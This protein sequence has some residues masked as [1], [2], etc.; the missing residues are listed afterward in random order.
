MHT[1]T[2][3][4]RFPEPVFPRPGL[5]AVPLDGTIESIVAR[6]A[7]LDGRSG[8]PTEAPVLALGIFER[9]GS[10]WLS[11]SLRGAMP[12]HNEPFRQQLGRE[13]PLSPGNRVPPSLQGTGLSG[14]GWH[15]LLCAL[16]DLHGQPRHL[17][18]ETN[19]FFATDTVLGMLPKSPAVVLTRAPIGIASSFARGRLW[20]RW[21]YGDRYAQVAATARAPRWRTAFAP[22]LPQDDPDPST[23]L[24]RLIVV[25][26]LLL[27]R[28]LYD[29]TESPRPRLVIPYEQHV[30]D[31]ARTQMDLARFLDIE[32]P[33]P[34]DVPQI[35]ADTPAAVDTTFATIG[36]KDALVAELLPGTAELVSTAVDR[37]IAQ[38]RRLLAPEVA[39]T[40]T[41]W[42]AGD[43]QYEVH[44]PAVRPSR[45]TRLEP[46]LQRT[47]KPTYRPV[48]EVQWRNL[49][50]SN[51]EM[52]EL[53]TMLHAGGAVNSRLGTNLLVCPMP[54]ERGGRL[55]YDPADR[56]WRVSRGYESHP[57]YW[58]T[59][60]GA[61]LMAAWCG[62]RL[63]TRAEALHAM[64][65]ARAYNSD[66]LVGDSCPVVESGLG[67]REIHHMVG[68]VQIWCGDGPD[69]PGSQPVQRYLLGAA[70][71][72]P[73]T[74]EAV[75]AIRSRYLLGSSRGVGVRLVRDP[76]TTDAA[77]LGA[78]ELAHQLNQWVDAADSSA[79][80]TP[81]GLDRL[82]LSSLGS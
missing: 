4:G 23:A 47:I 71:N 64:K 80:T 79:R 14:L 38:A 78:W 57:A 29:G 81:G 9:V 12:Q 7:H 53:L 16:S 73:G 41:Q 31:P 63:P 17:V 1:P 37:T 35:A 15:H 52:A 75:T 56:R 65:G 26:A 51:T 58:I 67:D 20:D 24:G 8:R 27:A 48:G 34:G 74:R 70:W 11:D 76:H 33:E 77:R 66:Y 25:N 69:Q 36:H 13:H 72:T 54:D 42:L 21:R 44:E 32:M 46:V 19:L 5:T 30:G 61:A 39:E 10:N 50:V 59:W 3:T 2:N 6:M 28:A 82:L 43:D 40:V 18:K 55:H 45:R 68:N 60:I 49:L 62:A 22:L